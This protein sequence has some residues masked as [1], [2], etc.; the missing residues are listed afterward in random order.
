[1]V[2]DCQESLLDSLMSLLD[3][4]EPADDCGKC[5][6]CQARSKALGWGPRLCDFSSHRGISV[7]I[8]EFESRSPHH[9][10][11]SQNLLKSPTCSDIYYLL[12]HIEKRFGSSTVW[13]S[14][15]PFQIPFGCSPTQNIKNPDYG[16][17]NRKVSE[18]PLSVY[19]S[20][21][22]ISNDSSG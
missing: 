21:L 17:R 18:F 2:A 19:K 16:E 3:N 7:V 12:F 13:R 11:F 1:M 9:Y 6:G 22:I 14:R 8:R 20:I 5:G 10:Y 15:V 4:P